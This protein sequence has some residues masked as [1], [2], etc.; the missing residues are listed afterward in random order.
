MQCL[1]KYLWDYWVE[2]RQKYSYPQWAIPQLLK[3]LQANARTEPRVEHESF[4]QY[5]SKIFI[6]QLY[7][8]MVHSLDTDSIITHS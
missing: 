3:S 4:L 7:H 8:L 1:E 6:Q 5:L 2:Y